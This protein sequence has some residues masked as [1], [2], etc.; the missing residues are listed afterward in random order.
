[1]S[2]RP[3][4]LHEFLHKK[5]LIKTTDQLF[6]NLYKTRSVWAIILML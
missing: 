3:G 6:H 2:T 1:M 5:W 4:H